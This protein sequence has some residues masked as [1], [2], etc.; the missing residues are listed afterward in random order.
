MGDGVNDREPISILI[1]RPLK[2]QQITLARGLGLN[3]ICIPTLEF[4]YPENW[5]STNSRLTK[6][7]PDA[8]AFT[9]KHGV[10]GFSRL[11]S[12]YQVTSS[13]GVIYAVGPSTADR[14]KKKGWD[15]HIPEK[16]N[17]LVL[18]DMIIDEMKSGK[19]AWL[20]GNRRRMEFQGRLV[21]SGFDVLPLVVYNT[22]SHSEEIDLK[23]IKAMAFYSP[24]AVEAFLEENM[25]PGIPAFAIGPT[26]A[27][28]LREA[29]FPEVIE[30]ADT[31]T[32]A[33]LQS[34]A[35]YY[36]IANKQA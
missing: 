32:E 24:S 23:G 17:A 8:F 35:D 29:G 10:E 5:E 34:I 36:N 3:P 22:L 28:T 12:G 7:K 20:C 21:N 19:I 11:S 9:S 14:L 6:F 18:A 16:H 1:T 2:S 31:K 25:I 30:S 13:A 27:A 4:S 33:L 15:V 26:T